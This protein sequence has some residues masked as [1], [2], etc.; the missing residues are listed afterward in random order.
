ME[1]TRN[2]ASGFR[3]IARN[4]LS[5]KWSLALGT[6]LLASLL[7]A[8]VLMN[9]GSNVFS[10]MVNV[11]RNSQFYPE[12]FYYNDAMMARFMMAFLAM[13]SL[14][15]LIGLVHFIVGPFVSF[16]LIQF[17]L[18]LFDRKDPE[19]TVIFS[20]VEYLGKA[21]WLRL[22][23]AIFILLWSLLLVIPGIIKMFSYSMSGYIMVENPELTAK[24]AMTI[25]MDMMRGNKWRLFCLSFSFIGWILL[26]GLTMGIGFL[27]LNPYM[28]AAYTAFYNEISGEYQRYGRAE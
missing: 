17:N 21:L 5:G 4:R 25:S 26:C 28:N 15:S 6:T 7:G 1:L 23:G 10:L 27:W 16:G 12:N 8:D 24:E 9:G 13:G 3:A 14:F 18:D 11:P 2:T 22:R 19:L 20:K